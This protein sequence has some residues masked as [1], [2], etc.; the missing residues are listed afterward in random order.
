MLK[1]EYLFIELG[2]CINDFP[3]CY[4]PIIA[5]D[6]THLKEKFQDVMFVATANDGNEQI[7]PIGFGFGDK[8]NDLSWT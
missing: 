7:Y 8:E 6:R 3:S 2:P 5:I 4:K 1:I